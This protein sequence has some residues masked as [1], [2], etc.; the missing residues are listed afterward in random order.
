MRPREPTRIQRLYR[1]AAIPNIYNKPGNLLSLKLQF[2]RMEEM[3]FGHSFGTA[4]VGR[5]IW[6]AS[7]SV[8]TPL[9]ESS[10]RDPFLRTAAGAAARR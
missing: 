7:I 1:L 8:L 9:P 10:V 3:E 4:D 6:T 2:P 5:S